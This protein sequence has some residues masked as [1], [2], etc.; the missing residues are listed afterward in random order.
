MG[1]FAVAKCATAGEGEIE[2]GRKVVDGEPLRG[3]V[4]ADGGVVGGGGGEGVSC[5]GAAQ[6]KSGLALIF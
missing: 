3:E 5:A 1:I 2:C 6:G 4:G